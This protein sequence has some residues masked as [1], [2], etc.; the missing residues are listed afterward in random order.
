MDWR[1]IIFA[2]I[3]LTSLQG[4][5][6]VNQ[7]DSL[8][9]RI[10]HNLRAA[11]EE[12]ATINTDRTVYSAGEKIFFR[13]FLINARTGKLSAAQNELFVDLVNEKD[14]VIAQ[15]LLQPNQF[16][17]DGYI[18]IHDSV[19][20]GYYWLRTFTRDIA[21]RH[22]DRI[23][24]QAIYVDNSARPALMPV[25]STPAPAGSGNQRPWQIEFFPEGGAVVSGATTVIAFRITDAAGAPVMTA[26]NLKD[27]HDSLITSFSS[28]RFGL[29]RLSFLS[30]SWR[31]YKA[32]LYP[33]G[34]PDQVFSLPRVNPF[35]AQLSLV[36]NKD[37]RKL[38]VVLEDSIYRRDKKTFV[39]GLSGDSLCLAAIGTGSYEVNIPEYRFPYGPAHFLLFDERQ[40]LLSERK[41][42]FHG[43]KPEVSIIT[44]KPAYGAR[45]PVQMT[46][47]VN[48]DQ[49]PAIASMFI[50]AVDSILWQRTHAQAGDIPTLDELLELK[51]WTDPAS[52]LTEE[53]TD[54]LMLMQKSKFPREFTM[55]ISPAAPVTDSSFFIRGWVRDKNDKPLPGR[56]ITL[57]SGNRNL[58]VFA[59][60]TDAAGA[61]CFPLVSYY[62]QT[63]FT[64]QVTDSRGVP[65][66]MKLTLDTMLRFPRFKTLP[67]L[68]KKFPLANAREFLAEQRRRSMLD[69][70]VM[71]K[72]WLQEVIVHSRAKKPAEYNR[73]KRVSSFSRI[74]TSKALQNGGT[75]NLGNAIFKINGVTLRDGYL[76]VS[77]G[78]SQFRHPSID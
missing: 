70:I 15:V 11:G 18:A 13:A 29:G 69:T 44:D 16:K 24:I 77:G 14:S 74:L 67:Q 56:T 34:G 68:R 78:G 54:L 9:G 75:N 59:D 62:D 27:D 49:R 38:R 37:A 22:A 60:T 52:F 21:S 63:R 12:W 41:I 46:V 33:P 6:Q 64:L 61:F 65:E 20:S 30:W 55:P 76:T 4:R 10:I 36:E 32:I 43:N 40:Q 47:A 1:K 57:F 50:T 45:Q 71:G 42:F 31:S 58:L 39:I 7:L 17:T 72:E 66:D 2:A 19:R 53:E 26:G 28:N 51:P 48:M 23:G 73:D 8:A 35:A 5:S 3:L 25:N